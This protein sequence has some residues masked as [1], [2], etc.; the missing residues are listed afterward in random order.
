MNRFQ[1][2][3]AYKPKSH[4]YQLLP[5]RF[6]ELN[7]DSFVATNLAGEFVVL[8]RDVIHKFINHELP[9][10]DPSYVELRAR[11]F[12]TDDSTSIA[13]DLLAI[14]IRSR[15]ERLADFTSLHM[16]VV[17]LRCEHPCQYCQVSR[18]SDNKLQFD[19]SVEN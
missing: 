15:Y 8:P 9:S 1:Q 19:M 17:S 10:T 11:S 3:E 4:Q 12:L 14:K 2:I 7:G 13:R 16:F 5:F 18:Q 6:T